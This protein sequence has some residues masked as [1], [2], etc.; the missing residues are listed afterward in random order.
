M[1]RSPSE[2]LLF[3]IDQDLVLRQVTVPDAAALYQIIDSQ[4]PYL[5]EWLPFVDLSTSQAVTELYLQSVTAPGNSKD[6]LFVMIFKEEIGGLI[7]FKEIDFY[8]KKLEVGYWLSEPM[9]GKG[10]VIRSCDRLIKYAFEEMGMNR[11][12]IK[13]GVG[14]NKSSK[15][16]KKLHFKPEG[17]QREAENLNGRFHDLEVYSLLKR[18]W[19]AL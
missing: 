9:Q 14:N 16:P 17:T 6:L 2:N 19:T 7:G 5:R 15:I 13:V 10:I 3:T 11:I 8:N 4:R 18:E 1:T 12:Q